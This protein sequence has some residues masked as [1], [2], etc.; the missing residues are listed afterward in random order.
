MIELVLA[1]VIILVVISLIRSTGNRGAFVPNVHSPWGIL[2]LI[3]LIILIAR[4]V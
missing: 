4:L 3:L 2:V 1:I